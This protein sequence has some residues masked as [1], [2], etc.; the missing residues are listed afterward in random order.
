MND[1]SKAEIRFCGSKGKV[2]RR[3]YN[4]SPR[5]DEG[6]TEDRHCRKVR[7]EECGDESG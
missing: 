7:S 1:I 5:E 3:E 6:Q 4:E 2:E